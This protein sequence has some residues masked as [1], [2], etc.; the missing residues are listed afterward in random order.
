MKTKAAGSS[1]WTTMRRILSHR[2][3]L[4]LLSAPTCSPLLLAADKCDEK[5]TA[6]IRLESQHPWRPPFGLE[7]VGQ[8]ITAVVE[9][10]SEERPYR[11]YGLAAFVE[12]KEVERQLLNLA[13]HLGL[14]KVP[15]HS[16]SEVHRLSG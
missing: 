6:Q 16:Q 11:E 2:A 14:W 3:F 1:R 9:V 5:V 12:G 8:P 15:V 7:R 10:A 13:G 4:L